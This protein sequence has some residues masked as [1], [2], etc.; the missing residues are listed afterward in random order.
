MQNRSAVPDP[1]TETDSAAAGQET[2]L[3]Q[4]ERD[5]EQAYRIARLGT[6]RW[7]VATDTVIWSEEVY[8]AFGCD[9]ALPPPGYA[10]IQ[11]Y[12]TM[13]TR[14]LLQGSV[15][16]ALRDGEPYEHEMEL[17]LADG[18]HRWIVTRGEVGARG[19]DGRVT[20]LSG[21]IQDI[22]ERKRTELALKEREREL[23]E[24]H[25]INRIGTWGMN[26]PRGQVWWSREVYE[27][28]GADPAGPP[29]LPPELNGLFLNHGYERMEAAFERAQTLG[30]PYEVDAEIEALDGTRRWICARGEVSR[31]SP[32]GEILELRGTI[33]DV[34]D[35][36][37]IELA[38]RERERELL[39][40]QRIARLGTFRWDKKTNVVSW[41]EEVYRAFGV[42]SG[43][44]VPR[45]EEV[46]RL[47]TPESW[48]LISKA[49]YDALDTGVPYAMDLELVDREGC[50]RRWVTVRGEGVRGPDGEV[51][52]LR[53]TVQDVTERKRSEEMLRD[54]E[55]ALSKTQQRFD[56]LYESD[57]VGIGFPDAEGGI[58]DGNDELLRIVSYS[59]AEMQA[60]LVRWDLM[61]PPEWQEADRVHIAEARERGSCTPYEKEY[62][63]KDGSRVPILCGFARLSGEAPEAIGFVMDLTVQKQAEKALRD[64]ERRFRELANTL[65]ALVWVSE[66]DGSVSYISRSF[67]VYAGV[68]VEEIQGEGGFRL[69]HAEDRVRAQEQW[70]RSIETHAPFAMEARLRRH[71][72]IY[73]CF[74]VQAVPVVSEHAQVE[75]WVGTATDVHDQKIAEEAVRRTE[76]LAAAGRLAASMAHE[77]NNPLAAV[78][79]TLY[80]ALTDPDLSEVTRGYLGQ[81]EQELARVAAVTT[82]TLRFHQQSAAP[83][84][85]ELGELMDSAYTLFQKRFRS[86]GIALRTE[87]SCK[88]RLFCRGD[89][90]RQVF[91]NLL[92]NALD[93]TPDGG[94]VRIRIREARDAD[95]ARGIRVSVADTGHGIPKELHR[96]IFEPFVSTKDATGTGLGLWVTLGIVQRHKGKIVMRSRVKS[97][98]AARGGTIFSLFFPTDGMR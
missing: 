40:A 74:L 94:L 45:G 67:E 66:A 19:E 63:R 87:Y 52:D 60:G 72:G 70:Q 91:A 30:E 18:T 38:L 88:D 7:I 6:W 20:E 83:A 93:A 80:L 82:Q 1:L 33:Q 95:G 41:S 32:S 62:F 71:D 58:H 37:A 85:V 69:I 47:M 54:R 73:R 55:Q 77:I 13:E 51:M 97:D 39:E 26:V 27:A 36:K 35:R 86:R 29:L 12:H 89:E 56:T 92:S 79:N 75:R 8:R 5:L 42:D 22:T 81:A 10:T 68:G 76:K 53:G 44:P 46:A 15:E 25:R 43:L 3:L 96:R 50:G 59:R 16:R 65:P 17:V 31:R 11:A 4:R 2:A 21:T 34:S 90:L 48:R 49:T 61:T 28:F 14:A 78:T 84:E 24:A 64:R 98:C 23:K 57:L 9:P